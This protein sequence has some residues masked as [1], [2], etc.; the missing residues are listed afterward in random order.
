[1]PL[2]EASDLDLHCLSMSRKR[3]FRLK[4]VSMYTQL[5]RGYRSE[6]WHRHSSS[7]LVCASSECSVKTPLAHISQ[8]SFCGTLANRGKPDQAPQHAASD[9]DIHCSLTEVSF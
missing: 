7:F 5:S 3:Y 9:Q 6:L 1:M 8:R 4:W 2:H